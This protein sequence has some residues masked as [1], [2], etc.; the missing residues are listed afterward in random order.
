[1]SSA[2]LCIANIRM[3]ADTMDQQARAAAKEWA[4][5]VMETSKEKHCPVDTGD[6]KNSGEVEI[7]KNTGTECHITLTYGKGLDYPIYV[8]EIPYHHVHG[9]WKFLSIPF[10]R[11]TP[12]LIEKIA[13]KVR[14]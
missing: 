12:Q 13:S 8:H 11:A 7:T 9:S 10:N 1:M 14:L 3:I 6:M 2:A 5:E 4:D